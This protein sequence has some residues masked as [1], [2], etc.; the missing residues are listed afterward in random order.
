MPPSLRCKSLIGQHYSAI[1]KAREME[2]NVQAS[3][4]VANIRASKIVANTHEYKMIANIQ[5]NQFIANM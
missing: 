5:T 2:V 4:I 1:D 3:I